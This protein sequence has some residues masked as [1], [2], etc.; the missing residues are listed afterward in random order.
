MQ[1][2]DGQLFRKFQDNVDG[3][4]AVGV[5]VTVKTIETNE[6]AVLYSD[7]NGTTSKSN[8]LTTDENGYYFFYAAD[9][10]YKISFSNGF[11]EIETVLGANSKSASHLK[12]LSPS[13]KDKESIYL[14]SFYDGWAAQAKPAS[15]GGTLV[16][17]ASLAKTNNNGGT[18]IAPE[19]ITAWNGT[20]ANLS[21]LSN[22]TGPGNGCWVRQLT[23]DP[24]PEMFGAVGD[25]TAD[26]KFS[27][28]KGLSVSN[29]K[30][31]SQSRYRITSRI[32]VP[33]GRTIKGDR[34][35][36]VEMDG[37]QFTGTT[38]YASNSLGF[39]FNGLSAIGGLQGF[40]IKLTNQT[41][42]LIAGA[43]AVR[44]CSNIK[45]FDLE[46]SGFRKSKVI[47]VDSSTNCQ[48]DGNTIRDCLLA[49]TTTGQLTGIDV[50]NNRV[51]S[52]A[53]SKL[54]ICENTILNLT[55]S[56][57]FN[58]SFGYQTDGINISHAS[59][60]K[61]NINRN[62]MS[63]VGEGVDCFG[64]NC[65]ISDNVIHDAYAF[66]IKLIHGASRNSVTEN[67]I[68]NAGLAGIVITGSGTAATNTEFN[69][70][71]NNYISG[72]NKAGNWS[73][74]VTS[75]IRVDNDN[76][77]RYANKNTIKNNIITD[78]STMKYGLLLDTGSRYNDVLEN[79]IESFTIAE[80]ANSGFS[81][82]FLTGDW[83]ATGSWF[84]SL[85]GSTGYGNVTF[86]NQYGIYTK[87]GKMLTIWGR[88]TI[89]TITTP[90]T[91][92][93]EI[94]N[95]PFASVSGD[96]IYSVY[97]A[98]Y[99]KIKL[100]TAAGYYQ[101]SGRIINNA[102]FI[103]LMQSGNN[104]VATQLNAQTGVEAGSAFI[105]SATYML[106]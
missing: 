69:D 1:K 47:A 21:A 7:S 29:L 56:T 92:E 66:G 77:A 76:G 48:I 5:S 26:D 96:N 71:S 8:P 82:S 106:P 73:S 65:C 4:A 60:S 23:D 52:V 34:T 57:G 42:E 98:Q 22:W 31:Q 14:V 85:R 27:I 12:Q 10:N 39:L 43:I 33:N 100:N 87:V 6:N 78:G 74:S 84:P 94:Y 55:C 90:M 13:P 95:L 64:S 18:I 54:S 62:T 83:Y 36:V 80:L 15:G 103:T 89:D 75:G 79:K 9:G 46:I 37:S 16:Y 24:T 53:S 11:P 59:S 104:L 67:K 20:Q 44:S 25:G 41:N 91:G 58:A 61:H 35:S 93:L 99:T 86:S 72:V 101:L 40:Q 51:S 2:Y 49:S 68:Y 50:D 102:D 105:F 70:V 19:A 63:N 30:L 45:L 97:F 3:I 17:N 28:S 38:Q 88:V 81:N 32:D